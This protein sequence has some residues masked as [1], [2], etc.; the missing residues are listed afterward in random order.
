MGGGGALGW[1]SYKS[2]WGLGGV[3]DVRYELRVPTHNELKEWGVSSLGMQGSQFGCLVKHNL[4][5]D[6]LTENARLLWSNGQI[7]SIGFLK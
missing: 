7:Q 1:F 3:I 4:R 5:E 2:R 6:Q